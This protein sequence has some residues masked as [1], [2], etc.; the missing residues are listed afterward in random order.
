VPPNFA[1]SERAKKI[2]RLAEAS[3]A[4]RQLKKPG[5][6]FSTDCYG[7]IVL[8][9]FAY[10]KSGSY[11]AQVAENV[12]GPAAEELAVL[13]AAQVQPVYRG[14]HFS[15]D[16]EALY[17]IVY[18][19]RLCTRVLA[20][21]LRFDCHS[22]RYLYKTASSIPWTELLDLEQTFVVVATVSDSAINHSQ[23]AA[24]CLKDAIVDQFRERCGERPNVDKRE[25]DLVF[26][27]HI[28]QNK[29]VISLDL[30][31]GSLHRRGYRQECVEAPMQETLAAAIIALS[32]WDGSRPLLDPLCGS[33]TLLCEALMRQ[34]RVPAA[35]LRARFGLF[36]LP[37]FS[38]ELWEK[39]RAGE[40]GRIR[41][42]EPG[43][44]LGSDA[45]KKAVR[46]ARANLRLLPH[47]E[48][49]ELRTSRFQDLEP[50]HDAVI[51]ANPPYGVRLGAQAEAAA[52]IGE[53]GSFLKHRCTGSTA[54][55]YFGDRELL[56]K[57]GLRPAWKKPLNNGGLPGV[58]A[59]YEMY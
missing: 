35:F 14:L 55:I 54:C 50:V 30:G 31:G 2:V 48:N 19:T 28:H 18:Q 40:D 51:V 46:A 6:A 43:L 3:L 7:G 45:D 56:K 1:G 39:V 36:R 44:I 49:V 8:E 33:G 16:Q 37:D 10:Q 38:G 23:Y 22:T 13:G 21:L 41:P 58:L 42:L 34:C 32:G 5:M 15:A 53:L 11:F 26:N 12:E 27:L 4:N 25:P 24:L 47:A 9:S 57:I 17:R 20:P 52:L 59:R 29:A